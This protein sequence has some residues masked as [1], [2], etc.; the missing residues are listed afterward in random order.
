M[1]AGFFG[2][3]A[4]VFGKLITYFDLE[5]LTWENT[6]T[7]DLNVSALNDDQ[8]GNPLE[9]IF[10]CIFQIVVRQWSYRLAFM[11]A[12]VVCNMLMWTNFVKALHKKD[13]TIVATVISAATN[14]CLSVS[15]GG[16]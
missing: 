1:Y 8:I 5:N 16:D 3:A 11:A 13:G 10:G 4:S 2:S 14:Y 12:M 15:I 7:A 6:M 9:N